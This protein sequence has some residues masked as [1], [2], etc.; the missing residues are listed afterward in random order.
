MFNTPILADG[1]VSRIVLAAVK[2]SMFWIERT[3]LVVF[4]G[5]ARA[6]SSRGYRVDS[7]EALVVLMMFG[8]RDWVSSASAWRSSLFG[9]L[10]MLEFSEDVYPLNLV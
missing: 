6:G 10:D 8:V 9:G 3:G 2:L 1:L 5:A 4:V 7:L